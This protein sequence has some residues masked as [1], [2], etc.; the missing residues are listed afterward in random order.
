[1]STMNCFA[2][3]EDAA[4]ALPIVALRT[5]VLESFLATQPASTRAWVAA[6][7]WTAAPA[8]A[9]VVPGTD[10]HP[11]VALAGIGDEQDPL[12]LSH[13]PMALPEGTY[14]LVRDLGIAVDPSRA[15]L[16][17]GLGGYQFDRYE[18]PTRA[19]ARL[20]PDVAAAGFPEAHARRKGGRRVRD[21]V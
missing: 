19:P 9:L 6:H 10:G 20:A 12:S 3:L 16:G 18:K 7:G 13:L 14:R 8:T 21:Q 11:V 15:V 17:W 4:R 5:A 2:L 1:M